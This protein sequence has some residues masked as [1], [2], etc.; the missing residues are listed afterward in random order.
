[1]AGNDLSTCSGQR[2][3]GNGAHNIGY[4]FL[5][6]FVVTLDSKNRGIRIVPRKSALLW[7]IDLNGTEVNRLVLTGVSACDTATGHKDVLIFLTTT[8]FLIVCAILPQLGVEG[9]LVCSES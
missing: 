5:R 7:Q 2:K 6:H 4:E 8:I 3:P 1:V 9:N